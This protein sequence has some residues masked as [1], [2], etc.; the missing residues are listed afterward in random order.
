MEYKNENQICQNCKK[1]FIIE[2]DDF[3]FYEKMK[4]P[5]PTFCPDCRFQRRLLFRNNR[6]FYRRECAMCK[7]SILSVYNKERPYVVYCRECWLSDKWEPL[8]YGREYDFSIPF[9][10]QFRSLQSKVPRANLYQTNFVS[11]EYCNYGL[12]FKECY[13]LFGGYDNERVYFANQILNSRD[14]LDIAFSKKVEFSYETF[15]CQ[16]TNKLFF[17]HHCIDCM[18]SYYL[19]DCRNCMN[20]F[21]C[22]GLVNKQYYV[23][24]Q[25]L[26]KEKYQE[27]IK[28]NNIGSFK[29]H[30]EFLR[31][32]Q[33]LELTMP[34]RFARIYK[35]TNSDGDDLLEARNTH[36]SFN[37]QLT[38][39]SKYL[40]YCVNNAKDC[41]DT[42]FQGFKSELVYEVAHGFGGSNQA[43]GVRNYFNQNAR[44]NEECHDCLNIFG[45]EGLRKK[46]YCI[47][48]KQYTKEEYEKLLP[49]II[50]QM[51]DMPYVDQKGKIYKYGEFFP[52]DLS[53]FA[54]N[55]TIAQ[56]Y[57]PLTKEEAQ[58]RNYTWKYL[59]ERNYQI[60]LKTK[61]IPDHIKG[62][63]EDII[64]QIIEC[65]HNGKCMEQCTEA[66]KIVPEE[67]K[68]YKRMS[69]PLPR[70]C[71]NCRHYQRLKLR[72]PLKLWDRQCMC[73]KENHFHGKD[74]CKIEF[75]TSYSPER[76]EIVYCEKCY[77]QEIY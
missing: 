18:D 12:D 8:D 50:K 60:T 40:F 45:C 52:S 43:F 51:D 39:D 23:F 59:E 35:S 74:K 3:S 31:K 56:E 67:I 69:L 32:L 75:K 71:P 68:F 61:D 17:S 24:N 42:S 70:L 22:V 19:T 1:D 15:E 38:E 64:N 11:S 49:K 16:Q 53:P 33:E 73:D 6:V 27:F 46:Q 37:S 55:E 25:P 34:H 36:N 58:K 62:V 13:L 41:Y 4:V 54:Y 76:L 10:S 48:N 47:L 14:S 26:T 77:Q 44:Y 72:N 28:S 2:K 29:S 63:R 21:D 5:A 9:F 66:F 30:Q 20:C 7:K 57:F 65:E